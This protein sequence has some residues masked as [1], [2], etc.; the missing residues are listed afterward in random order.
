VV[1]AYNEQMKSENRIVVLFRCHNPSCSRFEI[2]QEQLIRR[3]DLRE[4]CQPESTGKFLCVQCG[5][6]FPL[7]QQEKASTLKMLDQEST[8]SR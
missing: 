1:T 6:M 7:S 3:T 4:M 5:E 8:T 2:P